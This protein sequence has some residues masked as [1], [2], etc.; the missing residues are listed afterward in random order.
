MNKLFKFA[1]VSALSLIVAA[2]NAFGAYGRYDPSCNTQDGV[3]VQ[4]YG[5]DTTTK[6][7]K[8]L[9]IGVSYDPH[10]NQYK[11]NGTV[12][13]SADQLLRELEQPAPGTVK[14]YTDSANTKTADVNI[15]TK[16]I[17]Y[18]AGFVDGGAA[19]G[20]PM[21]EML[22]AAATAVPFNY[23]ATTSTCVIPAENKDNALVRVF[24][25]GVYDNDTSTGLPDIRSLVL[26]ENGI[27]EAV[28][29]LVYYAADCI[30]A[31]QE[32]TSHATCSFNVNTSGR[33][34]YKNSCISGYSGSDFGDATRI[35]IVDITGG[36]V[37]APPEQSVV[38]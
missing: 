9:E 16:L 29:F 7:Y 20:T 34:T 10:L 35:C 30:S 5:F 4:I 11:R 32:E 21:A 8:K 6:K 33:V 2:P 25:D 18:A 19:E 27:K 3:A 15:T 14:V 26:T 31:E 24:N 36:S 17:P 28:S 23:I 1:G 13:T 12:I 22:T 37:I 38:D